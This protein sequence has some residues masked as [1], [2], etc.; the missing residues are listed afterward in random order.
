MTR[1]AWLALSLW[2]LPTAAFAVSPDG[3]TLTAPAVG[4]SLA[5]SSGRL[6]LWCPWIS[7][8][9]S[10][11]HKWQLDGNRLGCRVCGHQRADI[12]PE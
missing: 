12:R 5:T 2:L 10:A 7:W 3:S 4:Q 9:L 6:L 8:W 11:P 1:L